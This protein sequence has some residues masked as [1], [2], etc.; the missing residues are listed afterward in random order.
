MAFLKFEGVAFNKEWAASKTLEQ[1][2]AHEKHHGL[3]DEKMK[4]IHDL[5]KLKEAPKTAKPAA[6]KAGK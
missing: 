2:I 1:F 5:C 6:A 3:S 4:E